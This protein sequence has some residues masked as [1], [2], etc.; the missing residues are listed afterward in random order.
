MRRQATTT[1]HG[2]RAAAAG[3]AILGMAGMAG[4]QVNLLT[5]PSFEGGFEKYMP[6]WGS[7]DNAWASNNG[8]EVPALTGTGVGKLYGNWWGVFNVSGFYQQLDT[9]PGKSYEFDVF[10][11]Q[12]T[13]DDLS[14]G[15]AD[16]WVA[17]KIAFFDAGGAEITSAAA[18]SR[19][20]DKDFPKDTWIDNAPVTATAPSG[21][22]K[23]GVYILFL[24]PQFAGG[25]GFFDDAR[26]VEVVL[27]PGWGVD[28]DGNWSAAGSWVGGVPN[29]PGAVATLGSKIT[30]ARTVS[31]DAPQTVG[32]V[33]FDNA[34]SYTLGGAGPLSLQATTDRATIEVKQ[35]AHV[36]NTLVTLDSPTTITL[37]TSGSTLTI[38]PAGQ[39]DVKNT[40]LVIDYAAGSSPAGTVVASLL[41]GRN[42]GNW[43]G[44][45]IVSSTAASATDKPTAIAW[46]EASDLL[47][48]SGAATGSWNG[49]TVDASALLLKYTYYGDL[50][51]DGKVDGDDYVRIDRALAM[52]L[53]AKWLNGDVNY[54]GLINGGDYA[55]IDGAFVHQGGVLSAEVLAAREA[56]FG[57]EYIAAF[58]AAVPEP[59]A[60]ALCAVV[61]PLVRRRRTN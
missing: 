39:L 3:A 27:Q 52:G 16:N 51:F 28:A 57:A 22:A 21:A 60:L 11:Y 56:Q 33:V 13:G 30:A 41:F 14:S 31:V 26:L 55:L 48:L 59:S 54:D 4:A 29:G 23:V 43:N 32:K 5:N 1:R 37:E 49:Q 15:T 25:A 19:I 6:D 34:N 44:Q 40:N 12:K 9:V 61:F 18:E 17:Q 45:G 46:A 38:G 7:F 50:N 36:V 42:G 2:L 24:Q 20:L 8:D 47:G 53:A 58:A 35:G 10:S